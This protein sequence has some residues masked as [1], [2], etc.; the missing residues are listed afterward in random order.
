M[1]CTWGGWPPGQ[2]EEGGGQARPPSPLPLSPSQT[3]LGGGST[4]SLAL[5]SQR[6]QLVSSELIR[7]AILWPEQWYEAL[8]DAPGPWKGGRFSWSG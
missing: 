5:G 3:S 7:T 8:E 4:S 1:E 6:R 2:R